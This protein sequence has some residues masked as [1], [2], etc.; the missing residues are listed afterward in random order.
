MPLVVGGV[1]VAVLV[2]RLIAWVRRRARD[3]GRV[4]AAW[5]VDQKQHQRD[6]RD[7]W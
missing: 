6:D 1:A 4:S 5:H 3:K 7:G 2:G